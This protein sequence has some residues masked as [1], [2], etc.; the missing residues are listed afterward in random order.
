[1]SAS[2]E[3]NQ[4]EALGAAIQIEIEQNPK[5]HARQTMESRARLAALGVELLLLDH[6]L[7]RLATWAGGAICVALLAL[8]V[9]VGHLLWAH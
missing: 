3:T 8:S 4:T 2:R 1:V 6:G 7:D 5:A 9:G